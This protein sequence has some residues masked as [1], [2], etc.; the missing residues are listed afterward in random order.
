MSKFFLFFLFST[1][2]FSANI[3]A[4]SYGLIFFSFEVIHEKRKWLEL[5]GIESF[6]LK[7]NFDLSFELSFIPGR[8]IY[9]G[10]IFRLINNSG[11]NIDLLYN[12]RGSHFYLVFKENYTTIKF[13]IDN[14]TLLSKWTAFRLHREGAK[15][16]FY[17]NEHLAGQSTISL[18]DDCFKIYFGACTFQEFRTTDIPPM[19]LRKIALF[20]EGRMKHFWPL[21]ESDGTYCSDSIR[22]KK[23]EVSNP[24]WIAPLH[25]KWR[26]VL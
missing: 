23:A 15:L 12:P 22:G 26:Q 11:Q 10:Y 25:Y 6:C 3:D 19:N 24:I 14:D 2:F 17:F 18:S 7:K 16:F 9:F 13:R 8:P 5:R 1:G 20:S 4:Q 21:N